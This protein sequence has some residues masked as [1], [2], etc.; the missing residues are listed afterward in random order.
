MDAYRYDADRELRQHLLL[1][2]TATKK[3][4]EIIISMQHGAF[5]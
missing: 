4:N 3:S 1:K 2:I 5:R